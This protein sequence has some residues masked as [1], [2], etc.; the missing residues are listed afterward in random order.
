MIKRILLFLAI[1]LCLLLL[2]GC[3]SNSQAVEAEADSKPGVFIHLSHGSDDPQ[4]FIMALSM[5]NMM[6][7]EHDVIVYFDIKGVEVVLDGQPPVEMKGM[8][9]SDELIFRLK[10]KNV[11]LYV[12]PGCLKVAGKTPG[13]LME[14][15]QVADVE[16]LTALKTDR[17]ISL[18]Y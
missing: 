4:R 15:I 7:D 3:Q 10:Q 9:K 1:T 13:E 16:K 12:C 6:A 18:D 2:N 17:I 5:A 14:G 11:P 8:G